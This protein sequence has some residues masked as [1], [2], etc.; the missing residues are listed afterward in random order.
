[1]E[2]QEIQKLVAAGY[3]KEEIDAMEKKQNQQASTDQYYWSSQQ[4]QQNQ[5]TWNSG[6]TQAYNANSSY[7]GS[8]YQGGTYAGY[9][10]NGELAEKYSNWTLIWGIVSI[11]LPII[12]TVLALIY[13]SKA[14]EAGGADNSARKVGK[15]I[16]I[17]WFV[18]GVILFL[19]SI[20]AVPFII[21]CIDWF[22]KIVFGGLSIG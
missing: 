3:T 6:Q 16:A 7:Q 13:S 18:G 20:A 14:V 9:Q 1:M 8:T 19:L 15:A 21:Y 17:A 5:G 11:F 2:L 10:T 4:A 12:G 22:L